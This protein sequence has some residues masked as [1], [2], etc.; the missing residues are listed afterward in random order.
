MINRPEPLQSMPMSDET[1]RREAIQQGYQTVREI[2]YTTKY[3]IQY[4]AKCY[5]DDNL[6]ALQS[7]SLKKEKATTIYNILMEFLSFKIYHF[8]SKDCLQLEMILHINRAKTPQTKTMK[9]N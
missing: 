5:K 6:Q 2:L 7:R 3:T 9:I 8:V 4:T 1:Q